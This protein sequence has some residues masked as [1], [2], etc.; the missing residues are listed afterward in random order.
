LQHSDGFVG[1]SF[2]LKKAE[3]MSAN[4]GGSLCAGMADVILKN[5]LKVAHFAPE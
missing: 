1:H 2:S 4:Q 3:G 5:I